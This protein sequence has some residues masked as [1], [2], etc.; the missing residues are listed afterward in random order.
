MNSMTMSQKRKFTIEAGVAEAVDVL[1][2]GGGPAGCA[3]AIAAA[4]RGLSVLVVEATGALGGNA[5]NGLVTHWL[6]GRSPGGHW[7]VGGLF[8][9]LAE[10]AVAD[11]CAILPTMPEGKTYQPYAWLPWFIHGVPLDPFRLVPFLER[12]LAREGVAFRYETRVVGVDSADGRITHVLT[13]DKG[14]FSAVPAKCV[15]DATGDADVAALAGCPCHIGRDG[16]HL[17][18]CSSLVFHLSH[19]DHAALQEAIEASHSPKFRELITHLR[20]TGEWTFPSDIYISVK[21]LADDEAMINTVRL[22]G[23]D[24]LDAASRTKAYVDGRRQVLDLLDVFR[25]HFPGLANAQI[26][27]VAPVLGIRESRRIDGEFHLRVADLAAGRDFP[28]TIGFSMYG[29]D[30]PDPLRPSVQPLVDESGGKFVNKATKGLATPIPFRVMVPRGCSNLLCPGRAISVERDVLGPLRE[31]APCM[32][33]G[34][35]CGVAA[36]QIASGV[37]NRDVGVAHVRELLRANGCIVDASALP[38]IEPRSDP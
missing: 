8:R 31:M 5:T 26:K 12:T 22:I 32:A 6:G 7:V 15:I 11:G 16:D 30:L 24:G 29:W 34:E 36:E 38:P 37:A 33:M 28:D 14:G 17:T 27:S 20:E 21:G 18:T 19:V 2:A 4:R 1:V 9:E 3:A 35:A 10:G 25:R 23:V 13:H